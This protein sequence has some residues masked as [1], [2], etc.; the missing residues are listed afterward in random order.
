[1][2]RLHQREPELGLLRQRVADLGD[3]T[4]SVVVIE[5][6]AGVG[7]TALV[8]SG[9]AYGHAAG[10]EVRV[11]QARPREQ[12]VLGATIRRLGLA[13]TGDARALAGEL[14]EQ[15]ASRA[16]IVAVDDLHLADEESIAAL[17]E[18]ADRIE[19]LK[20]LLMVTLRP[21]EWPAGDPRLDRLHESAR[22][23]VLCPPALSAVSVARVL[24]DAGTAPAPETV[25]EQARWTAGNPCLLTAVA[26]AGGS[27]G[28]IPDTVAAAVRRELGRL[29]PA[30]VALARALAILGPL[31]PLRRVAR[32]A[33][34]DRATAEHA[35]DR[36]AR[37][38]LLAPGDPLRFHA[39]IEG[40]AVADALEP[41]ERARAHRNAATVLVEDG[42]GAE[43]VAD[44][45]LATSPAGDPEVFAALAAA[46]ERALEAGDPVL[47]ARYLE[48][49]LD[50]PPP[51]DE[52]DAT[53]LALVSAEVRC[54][55]PSSVDR[56][57]RILDRLADGR[58][59]AEVL[60]QLATLQFLR[61]QPDRAAATLQRGLGLGGEDESMREALLG[62][63]LA[64]ASFA[65]QLRADASA[66]FG[67]LMQ[68]IAAGG[69]LPSAPGLL[70]QVVGAMAVGGAPRSAVLEIVESLLRTNPTWD[71]PPFGLFADWI[72]SACVYTDE[73]E[74]AEQVSMRCHQAACR[75]GDVV[76]QC[77]TSYWLG[78]IHLHQGRLNEAVTRLE[79]A[80]RRQDAGWTSAVPWAAAALSV[81]QL[82]RGRLDDAARA[83]DHA[84]DADPDGFHTS[85]LLEARG[86]LALATG[87]AAV[88]LAHYE[89]SGRHLAD[90]FLVDA[91]T[92]ITWRSNA[93][94]AISAQ[95][96]DLRRARTLAEQELDRA[97]SMGA[98]RQQ[99]RALR[100]AAAARPGTEKALRL[101]REAQA[102]IAVVGPRLENLH[103][104]ADLGA[105]LIASG[106]PNAA[107]DPLNRALEALETSGA[108]ALA[109][110]V[111]RLLRATG[112]RPRR[113]A[114]AGVGALTAAELHVATL[115]ASG[116]SNRRIAEIL[117]VSER[118]VESHLYNTFGKLGVH[119]RDELA[120]HLP[121]DAPR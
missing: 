87:D 27:F 49:A 39:P 74:R 7:K 76:R 92:M 67:D 51:A 103:V 118:T 71:G 86:H 10:Y 31:A 41:F 53:V 55:R 98:A 79:A 52:R 4:G 113:S 90:N 106:K 91:P 14:V 78:L 21:G 61:N 75:A 72:A 22:D 58:P 94:F 2:T 46:G 45:F 47:A 23:G 50:E 59:R 115:A 29:P 54:G 97:R 81:A 3:G 25:E 63:Y 111:R 20:L 40:A 96:G 38:G 93:V 66:R 85:V 119:R 65:P 19:D 77:L 116:H 32:L 101:L 37:R 112:T 60:R 82:E 43:E 120:R 57:D 42:A 105:A 18:V 1:M 108:D 80:L 33:A 34:L 104:L 109:A 68:A 121:A 36:L 110:R 48:R 12:G 99:A 83:L 8:D 17:V 13:A 89:A 5:G 16:L 24:E 6:R 56:L 107:R 84:K 44:Q 30:E 35:A 117:T 114:R 9:M 88:A 64:A 73:L 11:A 100:A 28:M 95:R 69:P 26:R 102:I 70:V 15:A 62:E